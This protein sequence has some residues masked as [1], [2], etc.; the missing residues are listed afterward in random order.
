[1]KSVKEKSK[2]RSKKSDKITFE[3]KFVQ[4]KIKKIFDQSQPDLSYITKDRKLLKKH[5]E[6]IHN[7]PYCS[8]GCVVSQIL[9]QKL[10][11]KRPLSFVAFHKC[12][13]P[14]FRRWTRLL[15]YCYNEHDECY[16]F[17]GKRGVKLCD[18]F[19]DCKKFCIWCLTNGLVYEP[20]SYKMYLVRKDKSGDYTLD[21]VS[22]IYEKQLHSTPDLSDALDTI[23][24]AKNYE[25]HHHESVSYMSAYTRYYLYDFT[26]EDAIS[27]PYA[28]DISKKPRSPGETVIGFKPRSFYK[29]VADEDSCTWSEFFS[30][31]QMTYKSKVP[32][33]PYDFLIKEFSTTEYVAKFGKKSYERLWKESLA[34]KKNSDPNEIQSRYSKLEQDLLNNKDLQNM[35]IDQSNSI[36]EDFIRE[37]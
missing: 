8:M 15:S 23:V 16:Q 10:T 17:F 32:P 28:P 12:Y 18:D 9:N 24:L 7:L 5:I 36:L 21:N 13:K 37:L 20:D 11:I 6:F 25:D 26:L 14:I 33:R 34:E 19:L 31:M 1:M 27:A 4:N 29:S 22:I 3:S 30:R 35:K 2:P